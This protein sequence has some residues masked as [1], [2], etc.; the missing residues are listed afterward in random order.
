MIVNNGLDFIKG[1]LINRHPFYGGLFTF[2]LS[3]ITRHMRAHLRLNGLGQIR[4][5]LKK[6]VFI[7]GHRRVDGDKALP[8]FRWSTLGARKG[9][10]MHA[11]TSTG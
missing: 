10:G 6:T 1:G 9:G 7:A 8:G 11:K 4:N 5:M 2:F 3:S